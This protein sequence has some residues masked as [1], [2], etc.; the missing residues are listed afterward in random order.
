[1]E[2]G[3]RVVHQ[4]SMPWHWGYFTTNAQG[5]TGDAANDLVGLSGDP[6]VTIEDKS[7][8]CNVRSGRRSQTGRNPFGT[9]HHEDH[10]ARPDRDHAAEHPDHAGQRRQE[11]K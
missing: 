4:I 10:S 9:A 2:L 7:F 8:A 3:D 11:L 6:N 5:V 1:M